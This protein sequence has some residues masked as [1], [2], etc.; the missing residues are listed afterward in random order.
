M[1]PNWTYRA[2]WCV[3]VWKWD[4]QAW[5]EQRQKWFHVRYMTNVELNNW[6]K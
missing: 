2:L 4:I 1:N 3:L 6:E 5:S